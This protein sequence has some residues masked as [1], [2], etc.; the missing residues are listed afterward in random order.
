MSGHTLK[1]VNEEHFFRI[2]KKLKLDTE[3]AFYFLIKIKNREETKIWRN[4]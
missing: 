4:P 3:K 2:K 1:G